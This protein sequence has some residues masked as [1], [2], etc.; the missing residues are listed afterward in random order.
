MSHD[1]TE[2]GLEDEGWSEVWEGVEGEGVSVWGGVVE[3]ESWYVDF[4]M[5]GS[6]RC[7]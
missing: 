4:L 7:S 6:S 2:F 1:D 5:S 3:F